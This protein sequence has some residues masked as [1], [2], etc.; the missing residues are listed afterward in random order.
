MVGSQAQLEEEPAD[1]KASHLKSGEQ[2]PRLLEA[3]ELVKMKA[4]RMGR[5]EY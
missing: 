1:R 3:R 4:G 2:Y 5:P